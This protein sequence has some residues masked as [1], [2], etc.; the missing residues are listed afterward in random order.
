[1]G[2]EH[3]ATVSLVRHTPVE[4]VVAKSLYRFR[5]MPCCRQILQYA[6]R[7]A[8]VSDHVVVAASKNTAAAAQNVKRMFLLQQQSA[9]ASNNSYQRTNYGYK[10]YTFISWNLRRQGRKVSN[11]SFVLRFKHQLRAAFQTPASCCR[12][13]LP[14]PLL[15]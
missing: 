3:R 7:P 11:T 5:F 15:L 1:M 6:Y 14:L 12:Q 8:G 4:V 10:Y 2:R 9:I 13:I